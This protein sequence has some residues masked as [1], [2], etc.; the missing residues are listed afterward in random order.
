AG[1]HVVAVPRL[2]GHAS[3]NVTLSVY[4]HLFPNDLDDVAARLD[5]AAEVSRTKR[6]PNVV[7]LETERLRRS[8]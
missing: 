7:T 1:A 2:L 5:A 4:S 8:V 3:P 6:G